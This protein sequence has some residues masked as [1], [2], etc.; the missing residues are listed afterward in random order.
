MGIS[1]LMPNVYTFDLLC[2]RMFCLSRLTKRERAIDWVAVGR[3][4]YLWTVWAMS[5][6]LSTTST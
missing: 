3:Q 6:C 1:C 5:D 2:R 4:L